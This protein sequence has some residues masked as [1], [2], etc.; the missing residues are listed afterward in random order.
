[1]PRLIR[2]KFTPLLDKI[3]CVVIGYFQMDQHHLMLKVS[4]K[5][6]TRGH[7]WS[8]KIVSGTKHFYWVPLY[9]IRSFHASFHHFPSC[10]C[11]CEMPTKASNGTI[12]RCAMKLIVNNGSIIIFHAII[13][14]SC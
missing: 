9:G 8:Q 5:S 7:I 2:G 4:L 10:F 11:I 6:F 3:G 14:T 13:E 12:M 1:M